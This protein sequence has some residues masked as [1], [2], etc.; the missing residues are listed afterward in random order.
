M[1]SQAV[2][3][4][5]FDLLGVIFNRRVVDFLDVVLLL[6]TNIFVIVVLLL[7]LSWSNWFVGLW[8]FGGRTKFAATIV[9]WTFKS[10]VSMTNFY[11]LCELIFAYAFVYFIFFF[12]INVTWW[13]SR[14]ILHILPCSSF[15]HYLL[16]F[17]LL[18]LVILCYVH[19][20]RGW[21]LLILTI[22]V[23]ILID[24]YYC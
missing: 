4:L 22:E 10:L 11:L 19:V 1:L 18:L 23:V 9:C 14:L 15:H 3:L 20:A 16:M 17:H 21:L 5:R 13:A 8:I 7:Y 24:C 6:F 12:F 2:T